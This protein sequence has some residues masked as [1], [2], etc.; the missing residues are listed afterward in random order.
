MKNLL[1]SLLV[2]LL[3]ALLVLPT[4]AVPVSQGYHLA[5]RA[6]NATSRLVFAHF[7][8]GIVGNRQSAADYDADMQRAKSI[9]IDAFALN[10]GVDPYTDTQLGYAYESAANNGMK[11]FISFDFNWW[12]TGQASAI[13]AKVAQ[14]AN[15]TAQLRVDDRVFVSSFAGDGL[16]VSAMEKAANTSLFFVPN[17]HPANNDFGDI[18]GALNWMAWDNNGNNKAP[19]PGHNVTVAE[20]DQQ[21][22]AALNGKPYLAPASAWFST[23]YGAEVSYSKNWV[24]PSD[25]LWFNRWQDILTLG[26]QFVEIVTWNDYG[27][28]H[29]VGPLS[30]PHTDDGASKWAMDM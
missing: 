10:I 28:S 3:G 5:P 12:S 23:H 18:D 21:Y 4:T 19:T 15:R 11:V 26:P 20:G 7:M 17:F 30:S 13:G 24:F 2:S 29:Y 6:S 8:I 22:I 9:G 27:E 25:L 16:D 1:F 14:Y